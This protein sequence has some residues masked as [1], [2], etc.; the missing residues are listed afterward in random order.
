M[1]LFGFPF[2]FDGEPKNLIRC[3]SIYAFNINNA[4]VADKSNYT[5][6]ESEFSY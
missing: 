1:F 5:L 3:Y 4:N 2:G 6:Q